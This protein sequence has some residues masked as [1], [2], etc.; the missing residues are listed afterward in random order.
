MPREKEE[1][2]MHHGFKVSMMII[3]GL[4]ILA[5]AYWKFTTWDYF[6]GGLLV[7]FGLIKLMMMPMH[8]RR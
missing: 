1:Y 7:L 6:I 2:M 8:H 5:N 4:L 3:V